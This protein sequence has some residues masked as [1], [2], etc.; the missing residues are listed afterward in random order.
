M[1]DAGRRWA[2]LIGLLLAAT[3]HAAAGAEGV[4]PPAADIV[5]VNR[6]LYTLRAPVAGL[7]P[8]KRAERA[9]QRL[10]ALSIDDLSQPIVLQPLTLAGEPAMAL[11]LGSTTL[12]TLVAGDLD[13]ESG[14]TLESSAAQ[15]ADR[16]AE[17]FAARRAMRNPGLLAPAVLR[18]LLGLPVLLLGAWLARRTLAAMD[19]RLRRLIA[20]EAATHRI[21]GIDW[22]EFGFRALAGMTRLVSWAGLA[23]LAYLW[24]GHALRQFP[25]TEPLADEM[26]AALIHLGASVLATIWR[27]LPNV[28]TLLLVALAARGTIGAL[29]QLFSGIGRGRLRVPGIHPDTLRAT[30]R[31][32]VFGVW[33]VALAVAYP[34]I[35]GSDSTVFRGLSVFLGFMF[36]LG[37]TGVVSQWMQGLVLVYSRALRIGDA[38]RIGEHEGV[39]RELGALS[40][41]V[42]DHRGNEITLPNSSVVAGSVV[43]HSRLAAP[44]SARASLRLSIGYDAPGPRVQALLLQSAA[45]T[46][47]IR[48]APAPQVLQRALTD[49]SVEYELIVEV[50][51][52]AARARAVS[53]LHQRI[54]DHFDA[55]GIQILSPHYVTQ[56]QRSP[57]EPA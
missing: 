34:H 1:R 26:R 8:A 16:L 51:T 6:T 35:P 14:A 32:A 57:E 50:A 53:D 18:A 13:V 28:A 23:A 24:F 3:V 54:R 15:S 2:A 56:P 47:G 17:A 5:H 21:L 37:S 7:P 38:V 9:V 43:N 41:K 29:D 27:L 31:L 46:P 30:R 22:S 52:V 12:F 4:A 49:F 10:R 45:E 48:T 19:R 39:V 55:A 42:V 25:A 40:V 11:R 36:T 44:G 20:E 33:G